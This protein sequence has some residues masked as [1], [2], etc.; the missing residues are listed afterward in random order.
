MGLAGAFA[1]S[2]GMTLVASAASA[3]G[4]PGAWW[5]T[6]VLVALALL[7]T[8]PVM[9]AGALWTASAEDVDASRI[10]AGATVALALVMWSSLPGDGIWRG[11]NVTNSLLAL[12]VALTLTQAALANVAAGMGASSCGRGAGT[13]L[14]F[15]G[16]AAALFGGWL[17][18]TLAS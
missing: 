18:A 13:H 14:A 11:D 6:G 5:T 3:A 17:A 10:H 12:L 16:P 4:F 15:P 1:A 2:A 8:A 7:A 9:V